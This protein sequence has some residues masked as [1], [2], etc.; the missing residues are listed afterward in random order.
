MAY[1][2]VSAVELL[3]RQLKSGDFMPVYLF[4][5]SEDYL[6]DYYLKAI[7][8]KLVGK[9]DEF[10]TTEYTDMNFS[11]EDFLDSTGNLSFNA[12]HKIILIKN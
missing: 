8:K 11:L 7:S 9:R 5:G 10:N 3:N 6:K 1:D 2:K 12:P 4:Y